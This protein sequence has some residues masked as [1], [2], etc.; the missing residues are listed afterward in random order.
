MLSEQ[1]EVLIR[2]PQL[3]PI[4]PAGAS[5]DVAAESF[6]KGRS[7]GDFFFAHL[8]PEYARLKLHVRVHFRNAEMTPYSVVELLRPGVLSI[9]E[10]S[11]DRTA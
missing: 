1:E 2:F 6:K 4:L 8:D 11:T 10:V 9:E 7:A 3:V 5:V